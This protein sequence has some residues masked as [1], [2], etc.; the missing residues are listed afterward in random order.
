M[1]DSGIKTL[2]MDPRKEGGTNRFLTLLV[3]LKDMSASAGGGTAF[4]HARATSGTHK[5]L[6]SRASHVVVSESG[7][8]SSDNGTCAL[9]TEGSAALDS[10][11]LCSGDVDPSG[12][13][14]SK[15]VLVLPKRGSAVLFYNQLP[16]GQLDPDTEHQGCPV[17]HGTKYAANIWIWSNNFTQKAFVNV[18]DG[19]SMAITFFNSIDETVVLAWASDGNE[20]ELATISA[21]ESHQM[22]TFPGHEFVARTA[23]GRRKVGTWTTTPDVPLVY[24]ENGYMELTI[25][26]DL[27][28]L[29]EIWWIP[30]RGGLAEKQFM[31]TVREGQTLPLNTHIGHTFQ[32][33]LAPIAGGNVHEPAALA[34]HTA[35]LNQSTVRI[36]EL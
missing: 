28:G 22:R 5:M 33:L 36:S 26:N 15:G 24:I 31:D 1:G 29:V 2:E 11:D 14:D 6:A 27:N 9:N 4:T 25:V 23:S 8:S 20:H 19:S 17:L 21:S 18:S 3:Y 32:F 12:A 30:S 7:C 34:M 16:D 13:V 10:K 35:S